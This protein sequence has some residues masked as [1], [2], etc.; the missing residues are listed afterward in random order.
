MGESLEEQKCVALVFVSKLPSVT[1][2]AGGEGAV[3]RRNSLFVSETSRWS[4][5]WCNRVMVVMV[6]GLV[7]GWRRMIVVV[8]G[9][10]MG[11]RLLHTGVRRLMTQI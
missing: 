8:V 4:L 10:V 9:R 11:G 5:M 7:W 3:R 1:H 2:R 6:I